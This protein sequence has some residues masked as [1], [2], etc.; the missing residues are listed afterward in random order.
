M[1]Y[2]IHSVLHKMSENK[3]LQ[4]GALDSCLKTICD[5]CCNELFGNVAE[6]KEVV[7]ITRKL[8]EARGVKSYNLYL[9]LSKYVSSSRLTDLILSLREVKISFGTCLVFP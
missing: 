5:I 4:V 2:T 7:Q 3:L 1:I 9:I 6:E 8:K